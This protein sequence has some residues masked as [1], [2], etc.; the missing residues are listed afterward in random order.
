MK[1]TQGNFPTPFLLAVL[2]AGLFQLT[3]VSGY[4]QIAVSGGVSVGYAANMTYGESDD[5]GTLVNIFDLQYNRIIGRVQ[6]SGLLAGSFVSEN[7]ESGFGVHGS[8]GYSIPITE[9]FYFPIMLSGGVAVVTYNN[10][11]SGSLNSGSIFT[12]ANPQFGVTL[13]PYFMLSEHLS[14]TGSL[15]FLRGFTVREE[16]EIINL[17]DLALGIR[18][19]L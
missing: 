10:G 12:D 11:F 8:L 17:T 6:Y 2:L 5:N 7:L 19:T 3:A 1:A 16:S 13:A 18:Y 15:R 4:A 9:H 14:V